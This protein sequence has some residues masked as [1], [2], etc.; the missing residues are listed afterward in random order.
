LCSLLDQV[1]VNLHGDLLLGLAD[2]GLVLRVEGV[3]LRVGRWH[4]FAAH[5]FVQQLGHGE[6]LGFG[7]L[8][9]ELGGDHLTHPSLDDLMPLPVDLEQLCGHG[10][11]Y[12]GLGNLFPGDDRQHLAAVPVR[13]GFG[14]CLIVLLRANRCLGDRAGHQR[15]GQHQTTHEAG[16]RTEI[17]SVE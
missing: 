17:E 5:L 4:H 11:L 12:L 15:Q 13:S 8:F 3:H 1:L 16:V 9:K 10:F 2:L 6:A 14:L 7:L